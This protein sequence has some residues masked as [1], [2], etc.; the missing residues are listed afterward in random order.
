MEGNTVSTNDVLYDVIDRL[1]PWIAVVRLLPVSFTPGDIH[2]FDLL[3][4]LAP[5]VAAVCRL[6]L[7]WS[8]TGR[9]DILISRLPFPTTGGFF[10]DLRLSRDR[11]VVDDTFCT[12]L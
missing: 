5:V 1:L 8:L 9:L 4:I 11:R 3:S 12:A 7:V 6:L 10:G 2:H